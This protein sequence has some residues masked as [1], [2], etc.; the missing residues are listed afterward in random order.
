MGHVV[1]ATEVATDPEKVEAGKDWPRSQRIEQLL[2][3]LETVG[4]YRQYLL[5][6]ATL[7]QP[8]HSFTSKED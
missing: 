4:Y 2:A 7:T 6:L 5:E 1:T 3:F 8:R